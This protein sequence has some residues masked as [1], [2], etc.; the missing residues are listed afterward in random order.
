MRRARLAPRPA[1]FAPAPSTSVGPSSADWSTTATTD[2]AVSA[3]AAV[4]LTRQMRAVVRNGRRARR[5][6]LARARVLLTRRLPF[7]VVS[8]LSGWWI[9]PNASSAAFAGAVLVETGLSSPSTRI[10]SEST[11]SGR[12]RSAPSSRSA[13][14]SSGTACRATA[15]TGGH[16]PSRRCR[17][18]SPCLAACRTRCPR[19]GRSGRRSRRARC[20]PRRPTGRA[21]TA[22]RRACR[23]V[24]VA[25]R[26]SRSTRSSAPSAFLPVAIVFGTFTNVPEIAPLRR[27]VVVARPSRP[28]ETNA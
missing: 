3:V 25:C 14:S 16:V 28:V 22:A 24:A 26:G 11:T 19:P 23:Q 15:A 13:R 2:F 17:R 20:S 9:S 10:S 27:D 12:S 18:R 6:L 1:A 8:T 7:A 21:P 5:E 4:R